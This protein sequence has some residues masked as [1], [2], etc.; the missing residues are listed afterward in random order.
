MRWLAILL[1]L[2]GPPAAERIYFPANDT[3]WE[4]VEPARAG[5]D[6][7][8]L[9]EALE[10]AGSRRSTAV[11]VLDRG[12]MVTERQWD[13]G[14]QK[15][16]ASYAFE[17]TAQGETI[18]DVASAQKSVTAV[19]FGIAQQR[20]LIRL[21]DPVVK[22]LGTGWSKASPDEERKITMRHLLSMSSGLANALTY[23]AEPGTRWRYNTFAYQKVMRALAKASGKS[24]NELTK[25]WLTGPLGMSHSRWR[26]RAELPGLLG[27]MT[28][29]R[30]LARFGL[31]V[32]AEGM[33]DKRAVVEREWIRQMV[34]SSQA[35]NPSYGY[36][37]WLN[38][39][40][41]IS[42]AGKKSA[43]LIP[44]APDDLAAALGALGRKVYV[45]PSLSLVVTRIGDNSDLPGEESFDNE[46]WQRIM[47]ARK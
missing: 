43:R 26:E 17:K 1:L 24:E 18:E 39:R 12:R 21:D 32:E 14:R 28:T 29:A 6:S 8:A 27:F 30:D 42:P 34:N 35:M 3:T 46:F 9:D 38:G 41:C 33:W 40:P 31:L 16:T 11:V 45:V 19:L 2:Q 47:R 20:G 15:T 10:F 22:Y 37:W 44:S 36:L 7:H 25:E 5:W 13:P 23:E 4:R